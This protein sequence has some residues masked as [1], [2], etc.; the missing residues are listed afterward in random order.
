M[1]PYGKLDPDVLAR[2]FCISAPQT[3]VEDNRRG[4]KENV[5]FD[6]LDH[7]S[8]NLAEAASPGLANEG[9]GFENREDAPLDEALKPGSQESEPACAG[10]RRWPIFGDGRTQPL[11]TRAEQ[12]GINRSTSRGIG[13]LTGDHSHRRFHEA[14]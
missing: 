4:K 11:T 2:V 14:S 10:I 9:F 5:Q 12:I 3:E 1:A 6:D 8:A 13:V 7:L